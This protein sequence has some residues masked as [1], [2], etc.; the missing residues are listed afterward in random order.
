MY[1]K[2]S[3]GRLIVAAMKET[4]I[5]KSELVKAIG[6]QNIKNGNNLWQHFS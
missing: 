5:K 1:P 6:Y 4:N 3:I 2:Y